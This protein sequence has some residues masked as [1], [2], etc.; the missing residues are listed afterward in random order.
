MNIKGRQLNRHQFLVPVLK[1]N[2]RSS[3]FNKSRLKPNW[4]IELLISELGLATC[5]SMK[6]N[7]TK[8]FKGFDLFSVLYQN[9]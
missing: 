2:A 1:V 9:V 6:K 8:P 7:Q 5:L 4:L 3:Q